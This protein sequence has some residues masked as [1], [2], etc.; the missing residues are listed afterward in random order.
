MTSPGG[1]GPVAA[2]ARFAT[3]AAARRQL[4][5]GLAMALP[6]LATG[7]LVSRAMPQIKVR[8]ACVRR[9]EIALRPASLAHGRHDHR[10]R[11][12][13]A[14]RQIHRA[15]NAP[16]PG[17]PGEPAC[18]RDF[19]VVTGDLI[20][21]SLSDLP[22]V[23]DMLNRLDPRRASSSA[24]EITICLKAAIVSRTAPA[25]RGCRCWW[26]NPARSIFAARRCS[27]SG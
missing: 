8:H 19:A 3:A 1:A 20:D 4:L 16:R 7:A 12:R 21:M 11:Q 24:K 9:M 26:T 14:C 17:R 25:P 15:G 22:A 27:F 13:H 10:P 2:P 6:P 5:G 23:L 18:A